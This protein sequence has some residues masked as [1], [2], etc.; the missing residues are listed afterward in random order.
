MKEKFFYSLNSFSN[1]LK[2]QK[3]NDI[4]KRCDTNK[5]K[6]SSIPN[7]PICLSLVKEDIGLKACSDDVILEAMDTTGLSIKFPGDKW[8]TQPVRTCAVRTLFARAGITGN[9]FKRTSPEDDATLLN[10]ALSYWQTPALVLIRDEM[11]HAIHAGGE[12]NYCILPAAD[13]ISCLTEHI[14]SSFPDYEF[15]GGHVTD[16]LTTCVFSLEKYKKEILGSYNDFLKSHGKEE[17]NN[18]YS[19]IIY[20]MTSDTGQSAVKLIPCLTDGTKNIFLGSGVYLKHDEH[21]TISDFDFLCNDIYMLYNNS[22]R[23]LEKLDEIKVENPKGCFLATAKFLHF[24]KKISLEASDL[25]EFKVDLDNTTAADIYWGMWD[26]IS[27]M[28]YENMSL[29]SY[30]NYCE[31]IGKLFDWDKISK[32]K[33]LD[34]SFEWF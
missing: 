30:I 34:R 3:E 25:F 7:N 12:N 13:L 15:S 2:E 28:D 27:L 33:H 20:F 11:I 29:S 4:W 14:S 23:C 19:P 6:V 9:V 16:E 17:L 31:S 22:F 32:V 8:Y 18:S 21:H 5:I 10:I 26:I 1:C 24:P